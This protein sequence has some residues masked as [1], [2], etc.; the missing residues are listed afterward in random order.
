MTTTESLKTRIAAAD[1]AWVD[2]D[3]RCSIRLCAD[4]TLVLSCIDTEED[5]DDGHAE[6]VLA[7]I[8]LSVSCT[9]NGDVEG[10][11]YVERFAA[12]EWSW[13]D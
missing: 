13:L 5:A 10:D 9:G 1:G 7:A 6:S 11:N 2:I 4:G 3:D 12:G 8:G